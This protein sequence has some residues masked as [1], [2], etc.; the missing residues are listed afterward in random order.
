M[1]Y[2]FFVDFQA[3]KSVLPVAES[4]SNQEMRTFNRICAYHSTSE[5]ISTSLW[6]RETKSASINYFAVVVLATNKT[7]GAI[8]WWVS[9]EFLSFLCCGS[10]WYKNNFSSQ[11]QREPVSFFNQLSCIF[12]VYWLTRDRISSD[13]AN[14][15]H[16]IYGA[17]WWY[18]LTF[19]WYCTAGQTRSILIVTWT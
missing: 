2:W 4:F 14:V 18:L 8:P 13:S 12:L 1:F 9:D 3:F 10:T 5:T 19:L 7:C 6:R 17:L 11:F 15:S 16:L